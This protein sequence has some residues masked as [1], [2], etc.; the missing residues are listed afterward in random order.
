MKP[1]QQKKILIVEGNEHL[2]DTLFKK[3]ERENFNVTQSFDGKEGLEVSYADHP[4]LIL[5]DLEIPIIDGHEFMT[6]LREDTWGK[7]AKVIILSNLSIRHKEVAKTVIQKDP[8]AF[9]IK[10][11]TK[12]NDLIKYVHYASE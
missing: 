3:L 10:S 2:N 9:L 4:D 5:L 6:H 12:L 11:S 1:Q 8:I 7:Q